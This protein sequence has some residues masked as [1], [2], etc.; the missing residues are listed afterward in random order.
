MVDRLRS[1]SLRRVG[2][3]F[4][5]NAQK[6]LK[7]SRAKTVGGKIKRLQTK[8]SRLINKQGKAI[9]VRKAKK[10]SASENNELRKARKRAKSGNKGSRRNRTLSILRKARAQGSGPLPLSR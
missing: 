2:E 7:G 8:G 5:E 1:G 4:K 3:G 6:A 9:R 10:F